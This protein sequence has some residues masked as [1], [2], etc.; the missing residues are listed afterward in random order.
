MLGAV[1][2]RL[3]TLCSWAA[4]AEAFLAGGLG[5]GHGQTEAAHAIS[6]SG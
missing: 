2:L 3:V 4:T 6:L 5:L 1:D